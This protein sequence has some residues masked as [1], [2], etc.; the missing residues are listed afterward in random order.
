MEGKQGGSGGSREEAE[1]AGLKQERVAKEQGGSKR[2]GSTGTGVRA[3]AAYTLHL[4]RTDLTP[5]STP[6]FLH[7]RVGEKMNYRLYTSSSPSF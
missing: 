3:Q 5:N 2:V 4:V 7:A 6:Y 1:V